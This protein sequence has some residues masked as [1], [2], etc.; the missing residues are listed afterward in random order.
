MNKLVIASKY[1]G[2]FY[3]LIELKVWTLFFHERKK[4]EKS[5]IEYSICIYF[6]P[7]CAF[8]F[9]WIKLDLYINL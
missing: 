5:F 1:A 6:L 9:H 3:P 4:Y 2:I 8:V 7:K